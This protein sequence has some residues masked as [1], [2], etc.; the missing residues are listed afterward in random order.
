MKY[1]KRSFKKQ[2]KRR[3]HYFSKKH[4]AAAIIVQRGGGFMDQIA[5]IKG[6]GNASSMAVHPSQ[7]LIAVGDDAGTVTLWEINQPQPKKLAQL[8]GLPKSVVKCIE[9][10]STLP[11]IAAAC[12]HVVLL[13]RLHHGEQE[14]ELQP[15]HTVCGWINRESLQKTLFD[16]DA[17]YKA[18]EK[19]VDY[20][21]EGEAKKLSENV[22]SMMKHR[23]N[24]STMVTN[25]ALIYYDTKSKLSDEGLEVVKRKLTQL[26]ADIEQNQPKDQEM[27]QRVN[28]Q[29][30]K[31]DTLLENVERL[32]YEDEL[33]KERNQVSCI[34]FHPNQPYIAVGQNNTSANLTNKVA[35]CRFSNDSP[36]LVYDVIMKHNQINILMVS[37]NR[38]G[39]VLAVITDYEQNNLI[40]EFFDGEI[41]PIK[42]ESGMTGMTLE[43]MFASMLWAKDYTLRNGYSVQE[44]SLWF[45][46]YQRNVNKRHI[47]SSQSLSGK[48]TCI[49]PFTFAKPSSKIN[50]LF[51]YLTQTAYKHKINQL[52]TKMRDGT[53]TDEEKIQF[54]HLFF[55]SAQ[56]DLNSAEQ[57]AVRK[58][59]ATL[60]LIISPNSI[61]NISNETCLKRET[62]ENRRFTLSPSS[63]MDALDAMM[64]QQGADLA[65]IQIQNAYTESLDALLK[66]KTLDDFDKVKLYELII[67][68]LQSGILNDDKKAYFEA[69][70]DR[71]VPQMQL[72]CDF[73]CGY[74]DGSFKKTTVKL[75]H[76]VLSKEIELGGMMATPFINK[77]WNGGGAIECLA[78][79][80]SLYLLASASRNVA[81][82]WSVENNEEIKSMPLQAPTR[83]LVGLNE[84][85]LAVFDMNGVRV[86]SCNPGDYQDYKIEM[87]EKSEHKKKMVKE[88]HP[89]LRGK[90][91]KGQCAICFE[92]MTD[93][94]QPAITSGPKEVVEDYLPCG[95]KF[96]KICIEE[97]LKTGRNTCPKCRESARL[98]SLTQTTPANV[99][100]KRIN[101]LQREKKYW[102]EF[103]TRRALFASASPVP[104]S[105]SQGA[106]AVELLPTNKSEGGKRKNKYSRRK[107]RSKKSKISR[108]Y[109]NK[110]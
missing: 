14:Q 29:K 50:V 18:A 72:E 24:L 39:N 10:H 89:E 99:V 96:H 110:K 4:A 8:V 59:A 51:H 48:C 3:R 79:H 70:K 78:V 5:L 92:S 100:S 31:R 102:D 83:S 27:K 65:D 76:N 75:L 82:L 22:V 62:G 16:E 41:K 60:K 34:A 106:A 42:R 81:K 84:N 45:N 98:S 107:N 47:Y 67:A 64:R 91:L 93:Q 53:L 61:K 19:E 36:E 46:K 71:I 26:E 28:A 87:Q 54:Q 56:S 95:H 108:R 23:D 105:T 58:Q 15:S 104:A 13:W 2:H 33:I 12:S 25:K 74:F 68:S 69:V 55:A 35:I 1:K 73:I 32:M 9:F 63:Q 103:D 11:F 109:S 94:E 20:S 44:P 7:P 80:P 88:V 66:I 97:W 6:H 77:S 90:A 38:D 21:L 37:F 57:E 17:K 49:T 86:Y 40:L 52:I 43:P 85:F 30:E 101:F